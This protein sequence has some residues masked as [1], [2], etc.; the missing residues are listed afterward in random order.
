MR[1][2][3]I[4]GG[5]KGFIYALRHLQI[6]NHQAALLQLFFHKVLRWLLPLFLI[7]FF[8]VNIV[9]FLTLD[10]LTIDLM[11]IGQFTFYFLATLGLYTRLPGLFGKALAFPTYFVVVNAAS[12]RALY[13][14]LTAELEATWETN[15]Y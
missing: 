6:K 5:M 3:V 1:V 7:Q 10:S 14:T 8:L 15:V 4:R 12:L 13:L 11:M 9:C 2:R